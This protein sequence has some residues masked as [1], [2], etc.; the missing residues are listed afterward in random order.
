[1][2]AAEVCT[3]QR[4]QEMIVYIATHHLGSWYNTLNNHASTRPKAHGGPVVPSIRKCRS[5]SQNTA[6]PD[7]AHTLCIFDLPNSYASGDGR[8]LQAQGSGN[9][10]QEASEDACRQAVAKLLLVEPTQVVLRPAHWRISPDQ[11]LAGLPGADTVHQAL[12]V[13]V[14]ARAAASGEDAA[15]LSQAEVD[16]HVAEILRQCVRAHGGFFDPSKISHRALGLGPQD[17]RMYSRLNKLLKRNQLRPFVD[18]HPEFCWQEKHPKGMLITWA[19]PTSTSMPAPSS[20][21]SNQP[22]CAPSS[23]SASTPAYQPAGVPSSANASE[24]SL[25]P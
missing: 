9:N 11:L 8:R 19:P 18:R 1:M 16:D 14:P 23:A 6:A 12:P 4:L 15:T 21:S 7:G 2:Q 22:A 3:P 5:Y 13:H 20:A 17:E 24:P 10:E 25:G